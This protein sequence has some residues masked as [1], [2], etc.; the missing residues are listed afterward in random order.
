MTIFVPSRQFFSRLNGLYNVRYF[1]TIVGNIVNDARYNEVAEKINKISK[2]HLEDKKITAPLIRHVFNSPI[3]SNLNIRSGAQSANF[4]GWQQSSL[5]LPCIENGKIK[6]L[7]SDKDVLI[8]SLACLYETGQIELKKKILI[9]NEGCD[10]GDYLMMLLPY[11]ASVSRP[12]GAETAVILTNGHARKLQGAAKLAA[13]LL[14]PDAVSFYM[15]NAFEELPPGLEKYQYFQKLHLFF[16]L[17]IVAR[18]NEITQFI[19]SRLEKMNSTDIAV[20]SFLC[21]DEKA[22]HALGSQKNTYQENSK[23]VTIFVTKTTEK[24]RSRLKGLGITEENLDVYNTAF[25][26]K[27]VRDLITSRGG[28]ILHMI[29]TSSMT[30]KKKEINILGVVFTKDNSH[31]ALSVSI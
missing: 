26:E 10:N 7:S 18:S 22:I 14:S 24:I 21:A 12:E 8:K 27:G 6:L 4:L 11:L 2:Q 20:A 23:D 13:L 19:E 15:A 9:I 3:T 30:D 28:K 31:C 16:R 1:Q 29:K 25:T 17:V 5:I